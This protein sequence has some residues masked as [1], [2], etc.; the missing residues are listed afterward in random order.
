MCPQQ[1]T[2]VHRN[3]KIRLGTQDRQAVRQP[4]IDVCRLMY[5]KRA[6]YTSVLTNVII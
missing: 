6:K 4:D 2:K 1:L 3:R 5:E